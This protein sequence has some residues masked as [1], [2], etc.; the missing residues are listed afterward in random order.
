MISPLLSKLYG[1][2]LEKKINIWLEIH[3][4]RAKGQDRFRSYH[5]PM[6][7][8]VMLR[9]IVEEC[10]TNK[11]NLPCR[12]I[13]FRKSF[14]TMPR[15]NLWIRSREVKVTFELRATEIRLY[16]NFIV[17]FRNT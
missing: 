2:I 14:V 1:I 16:K 6:D 17:R 12:F 3:G 15:T 9:I 13:D 5:S 7:H 11:T 10:R 8:L 4:K